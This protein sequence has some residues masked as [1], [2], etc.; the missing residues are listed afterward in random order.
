MWPITNSDLSPHE[1]NITILE[2]H[3][4]SYSNSQILS[5]S[6]A[7][8]SPQDGNSSHLC[9]TFLHKNIDYILQFFPNYFRM[10][11][12]SKITVKNY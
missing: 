2:C 4:L 11:Q 1:I 6:F 7:L 8:K 9:C 12:D 5:L 10:A 3:E